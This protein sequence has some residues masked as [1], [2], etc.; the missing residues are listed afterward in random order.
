MPRN[1]SRHKEIECVCFNILAINY[2]MQFMQLIT[3]W[4]YRWGYRERIPEMQLLLQP[5]LNFCSIFAQPIKLLSPQA[6]KIC[7]PLWCNSE[8]VILHSIVFSPATYSKITEWNDKTKNLF[9]TIWKCL[10]TIVQKYF[11]TPITIIL[12]LRFKQNFTSV[13]SYTPLDL[14][15]NLYCWSAN[16]TIINTSEMY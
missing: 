1:R 14:R 9:D 5:I 15:I 8:F 13:I 7:K 11:P 2:L 12:T 16:A 6:C 3:W 4:C 10:H